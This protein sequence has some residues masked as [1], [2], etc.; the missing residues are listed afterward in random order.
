MPSRHLGT[1]KHRSAVL[2]RLG[3]TTSPLDPMIRSTA[4]SAESRA[5]LLARV[6]VTAETLV[7][8]T[9]LAPSSSSI[10]PA[11]VCCLQPTLLAY[12]SVINRFSCSVCI[13]YQPALLLCIYRFESD[14]SVLCISLFSRPY[15]L[16]LVV[17]LEQIIEH[18][19]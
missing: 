2:D 14:P 7:L 17:S 9:H 11:Y 6:N 3:Q 5:S 13:I 12:K 18:Q 1:Q 16:L 10:F 15:I 8:R 19:E 4:R